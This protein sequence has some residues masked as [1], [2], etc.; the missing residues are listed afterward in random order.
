MKLHVFIP[1]V[2]VIEHIDHLASTSF[3]Y[4][5]LKVCQAQRV[6]NHSLVNKLES[7]LTTCDKPRRR[8]GIHLAV[9]GL[10]LGSQYGKLALSVF[11]VD[12]LLEVILQELCV[13]VEHDYK[14]HT[15]NGTRNLDAHVVT[16]GKP[17]VPLFKNYPYILISL[18]L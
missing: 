13:V 17:Q 7:L 6:L 18:V 2:I 3:L 9:P 11:V 10:N 15:R 16:A 8:T 1:A 4:K 14:T 5:S 12:E